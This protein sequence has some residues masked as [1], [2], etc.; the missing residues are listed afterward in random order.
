MKQKFI[1]FFILFFV[2]FSILS[3]VNVAEARKN[4]RWVPAHWSHGY[5]Y[6]SQKVCYGYRIHCEWVKN[7][8]HYG[9]HKVCWYR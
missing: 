5:W 4:C 1:Q 9:G 7:Y 8:R 2:T 6:P 3:T